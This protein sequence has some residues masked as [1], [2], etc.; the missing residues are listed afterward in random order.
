MMKSKSVSI[1]KNWKNSS[2][3]VWFGILFLLLVVVRGQAW[4]RIYI[5]INAPSI[6]RIQIAVP[7][8][9]NLSEGGACPELVKKMP[10]VLSNDLDLSG[11]FLPMDEAAFLDRNRAY[12]APGRI[13]FK[14]WSVIGAELL[15]VGNSTCIGRSVEAEIRLYDTFRGQQILGRRVLGKIKDY[16]LLM[17][18]IG[19][20]IIKLLT[21]QQGV[22]HTKLA[23]VNKTKKYKEIYLCDFDGHNPKRITFD[24]DLALFPRWSPDGDRLVYNSFKDGGPMLYLKDMGSGISRRISGR[25]G[26][27][28]GACWTADG[29]SLSLT[30]SHGDNPDIYLIDLNG[31]ILKRLTNHWAI[32]V[33]PSYSPD[34]TKI[35]FV[36]NRSG[37]PQIYVRDL[38]RDTEER[39]SF[40]GKYNTSP[41]WSPRN[42]IAFS[43]GDEGARNIFTIN[44]DGTNLRQ[45][46]G[47][48]R[49]NEEPCW[50]PDG[51]YVA[52]QS[53][54]D[55][56]YH[57]Y[58]MN[59]NGQNHRRIT[60]GGQQ[61]FSPSWSPF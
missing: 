39:I 21:G 18:R 56:G 6:P 57:I 17:H 25:Q 38:V 22:F 11:F 5:D 12:L 59:E 53:N 3:S 44:P 31:K 13:R 15:L 20:E 36:S 35:A 55:G 32:D 8:F 41:A 33:S 26:L 27:N 52:F 28:I 58:I 45:L 47:D 51:R 60:T 1:L 37:N 9:D 46:T 10:A 50:S 2:R 16:R 61:Q 42:R 48:Q 49:N 7:D 40:E 14:N 30:L 23:Y 34:G 54:R 43:S 4:G 29:K 24:K 19:N